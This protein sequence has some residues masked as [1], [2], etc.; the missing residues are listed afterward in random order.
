MSEKWDTI[1]FVFLLILIIGSGVVFIV[2]DILSTKGSVTGKVIK[3]TNKDGFFV[4]RTTIT[5]EH[6]GG[7]MFSLISYS[8]EIGKI[9][10][11]F[12]NGGIPYRH[13]TNIE[14]VEDSS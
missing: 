5:F 6:I 9:Y 7:E 2:G 14:L 1:I 10:T 3:V 12:Y 8:F 13:I 11:I 4:K